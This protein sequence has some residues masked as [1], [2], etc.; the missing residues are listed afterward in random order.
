MASLLRLDIEDLLNNAKSNEG[1]VRVSIVIH[2]KDNDITPL[3]FESYILFRDFINNLTDYI[4]LECHLGLGDI[5]YD[6]YPYKGNLEVTINVSNLDANGN[7]YKYSERCKAVIL[8]LSK[9]MTNPIYSKSTKQQLNDT[10]IKTLKLQCYYREYEVLKDRI[11]FCHAKNIEME[12]LIYSMLLPNSTFTEDLKIDGKKLDYNLSIIP[13]DNTETYS[14]VELFHSYDKITILNF[15]GFLQEKYGVYNGFINTYITKNSF[16]LKTNKKTIKVYPLLLDK[17]RLS[18]E[19]TCLMYLPVDINLSQLSNRTY[20]QDGDNIKILVSKINSM[21][22]T[23]KYN[24]LND[25]S[26]IVTMHPKNLVARDILDTSQDGKVIYNKNKTAVRQDLGKLDDGNEVIVYKGIS[27]NNYNDR[28]K[29]LQNQLLFMDVSWNFGNP[30]I[31]YPG[32]PV[33]LYKEEA[34]GT[35]IK[36]IGCILRMFSFYSDIH[37][38]LSTNISLGLS[39]DK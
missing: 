31:I 27:A 33:T 30:D 28:S 34:D 2:T 23:S 1:S 21:L 36:Y 15:P 10:V 6:I 17:N 13:A 3:Y 26:G 32:M 29:I 38:S 14:K 11:V 8:N 37:K 18:K 20:Y 9:D 24:L 7:S 35:V 19:T 39:V 12:K 4:V 22:D 5:F 16:D 25:G